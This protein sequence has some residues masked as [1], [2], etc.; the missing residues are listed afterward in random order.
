MM[1]IRLRTAIFIKLFMIIIDFN[2]V[3]TFVVKN[4][5]FELPYSTAAT[6]SRYL[7]MVYVA[8]KHPDVFTESKNLSYNLKTSGEGLNCNTYFYI[9]NKL[10]V[11]ICK[12][13]QKQLV[14]YR[15]TSV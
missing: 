7:Y 4:S 3:L 13:L 6:V 9:A 8:P 11:L 5:F 14:R 12:S 10:N 2:H 1:I 15:L